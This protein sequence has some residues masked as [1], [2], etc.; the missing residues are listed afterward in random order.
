MAPKYPMSP[1]WVGKTLNVTKTLAHT[2]NVLLQLL[3]RVK[4]YIFPSIYFWMQKKLKSMF[5][6]YSFANAALL[7][8]FEVC[9][10]NL[11]T[12]PSLFL[13]TLSVTLPPGS[14]LSLLFI[15]LSHL[16]LLF[17]C[18]ATRLCLFSNSSIFTYP[19]LPIYLTY[20][21][22]SIFLS[23]LSLFLSH[24]SLCRRSL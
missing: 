11:A 23:H 4:S 17:L 3:K 9:L 6:G 7:L 12:Q 1:V 19:H 24:L 5:A 14:L 18:F 13:A 8:I 20:S 10:D 16:Y 22:P 15:L 21:N 2:Q